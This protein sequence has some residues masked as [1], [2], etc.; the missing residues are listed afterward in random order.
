[1]G[2][3]SI[4]FPIVLVARD[5]KD[6]EAPDDELC[7][8]WRVSG[9]P[10]TFPERVD[11]RG[12]WATGEGG[13]FSPHGSESESVELELDMGSVNWSC[14][15]GSSGSGKSG[16]LISGSCW[17]ITRGGAINRFDYLDYHFECSNHYFEHSNLHLEYLNLHLQ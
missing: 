10:Y 2:W 17:W 5:K 14:L 8:R 12:D 3:L 16:S 4:S 13:V 1:M 15:S 7:E 6:E 11:G 9:G